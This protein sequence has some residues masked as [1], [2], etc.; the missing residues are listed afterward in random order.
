MVAGHGNGESPS[1]DT[2]QIGAKT[3]A[4]NTQNAENT[5]KEHSKTKLQ[6]LSQKGPEIKV[7]EI[8]DDDSNYVSKKMNMNVTEEAKEAT[9]A[10]NKSEGQD[11]VGIEGRLT[12]ASHRHPQVMR[13]CPSLST[14]EIDIS[15]SGK[16][17]FYFC[18]LIQ[19]T[20]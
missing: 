6:R 17:H 18:V 4:A 8:I 16:T 1:K 14:N 9:T 5:S 3:E 13:F 7:H 20:I 11:K 12:E 2:G 15:V 10:L 19:L